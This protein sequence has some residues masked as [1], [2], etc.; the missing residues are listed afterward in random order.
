MENLGWKCCQISWDCWFLR[1][2]FKVMA[3][4]RYLSKSVELFQYYRKWFVRMYPGVSHP[5][6]FTMNFWSFWL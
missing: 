4:A 2:C 3:S 1:P 5:F 6:L